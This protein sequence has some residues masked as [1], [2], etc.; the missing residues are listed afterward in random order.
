MSAEQTSSGSLILGRVRWKRLAVIL[1]PAGVIA[2]GLIGLTA[3]GAIASN[4]SVSGQQFLVTSTQLKGTGFEQFGGQVS[5]SSGGARPVVVS[6]IGSATLSNLCQ[7]VS[8]GCSSCSA[9]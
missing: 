2:F 1:V 8:V 6:G 5:G 9:R 7:S 4:I 3:Q